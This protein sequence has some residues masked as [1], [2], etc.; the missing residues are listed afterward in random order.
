MGLS[1]TVGFS[2]IGL[3]SLSP[4]GASLSDTHTVDTHRTDVFTNARLS[5]TLET[6]RVLNAN[7]NLKNNFPS[8]VTQKDYTVG[9]MDLRVACGFGH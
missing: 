4:S 8:T 7:F 3:S 1:R 5:A 9:K 2:R 6:F